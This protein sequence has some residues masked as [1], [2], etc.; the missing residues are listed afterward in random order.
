MLEVSKIPIAEGVA[1]ALTHFL[2]LG[3]EAG[4]PCFGKGLALHGFIG[5]ALDF[6][7]FLSKERALN[8]DWYGLDL[9]GHGQ[10]SSPEDLEL[11]TE[12]SYI[13]HLDKVI[14][15]LCPG[16]ERITLLAYSFGGRLALNYA[17]KRP[18]R[19]ERLIIISGTPGMEEP[20]RRERRR[21]AD[22]A[23]I[24]KIDSLSLKGFI[25]YWYDTPI[26]QSQRRS[27]CFPAL[28]ARRLQHT[29]QGGI[30]QSLRAFGQ[31]VA[32]ST[33]ALLPSL[34]VPVLWIAGEE[35]GPYVEIAQKACA[36]LP[37]AC[38]KIIP[39]VGHAPHLE[40]E[41]ATLGMMG[42]RVAHRTCT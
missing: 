40:D 27:P 28:Y 1:L 23:V 24:E 17:V 6:E 16:N 15:S 26:I 12:A 5:E 20:E 36:L 2:R 33:W 25:D 21:L 10:S 31:G 35:D 22:E 32:P 34:A 3:R 38:L 37:K 41:A 14:D 39:G 4:R 11:Y 29:S 30:A 42:G 8:L 13:R 9:L 19:L 7:S 18:E